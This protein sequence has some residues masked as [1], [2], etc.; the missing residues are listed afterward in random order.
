ML[1]LFTLSKTY[2]A[3]CFTD[4]FLKRFDSKSSVGKPASANMDNTPD[5]NSPTPHDPFYHWP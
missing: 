2:M 5:L 4:Y 1:L 3:V